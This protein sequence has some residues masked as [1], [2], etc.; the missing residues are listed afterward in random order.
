MSIQPSHCSSPSLSPQRR[1]L[2]ARNARLCCWLASRRRP[3]RR[4]REDRMELRI[5]SSYHIRFCLKLRRIVR[6]PAPIV[7]QA[8]DLLCQDCAS[9]VERGPTCALPGQF[10]V[11]R[12]RSSSAQIF[13]ANS[14]EAAG[15]ATMP[16]AGRSTG[17]KLSPVSRP[18][19][20]AANRYAS[21]RSFVRTAQA[22]AC[23]AAEDRNPLHAEVL[24]INEHRAVGELARRH[25]AGACRKPRGFEGFFNVQLAPPAVVV[26]AVGQVAV[27]LRL[28]QNR[29]RPDGVHRPGIHKDHVAGCDRQHIQALLQRSRREFRPRPGRASCRA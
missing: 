19:P 17:S 14:G 3:H 4:R 11:M 16:Q 29:S 20:A 21:P 23:A 10:G 18:A 6:K 15:T 8:P 25:F 26:H 28:Q 2:L 22:C 27:L 9:P 7:A 24:N 13:D 12:I 1:I 5:E